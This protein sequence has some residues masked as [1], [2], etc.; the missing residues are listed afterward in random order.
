MKGAIKLEK[1]KKTNYQIEVIEPL[2]YHRADAF[3]AVNK[4]EENDI[5]NTDSKYLITIDTDFDEPFSNLIHSSKKSNIIEDYSENNKY[6]QNRPLLRKLMTEYKS[7]EDRLLQEPKVVLFNTDTKTAIDYIIKNPELKSK[8]IVIT[9]TILEKIEIEELQK[10]AQKFPNISIKLDENSEIISINEYIQTQSII[11]NIVKYIKQFNFSPME[12]IMC[13]YDI[14]RERIYKKEDENE[15]QSTSRDLTSVL[16]GDKIVCLGYSEIFNII[17]N[18]LDIKSDIVAL[19][20]K[21]NLRNPGHARNIAY[22]KDDK[23]NIDGVYYFDTT[24]DSKLKETDNNYFNKYKY[25]AQ[26]QKQ[27]SEK[28]DSLIEFNNKRFL[29]ALKCETI[30]DSIET[31]ICDIETNMLFYDMTEETKWLKHIMNLIKEISS[32]AKITPLKGNL[33]SIIA[34]LPTEIMKSKEHSEKLVKTITGVVTY[35]KKPIPAETLIEIL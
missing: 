19:E 9:T 27:I 21:Y 3:S 32:A 14:V 1:S 17:L 31:I 16:L 28:T 34:F 35:Y 30:E 24:G 29:D 25:F 15:H 22:V 20:N 11:N 18:K 26:T 5:T 10:I 13:A 12:K 6:K 2:D 4:Y 7:H 23:Y 8:Q 33:L